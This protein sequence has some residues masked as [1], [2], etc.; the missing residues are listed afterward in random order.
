MDELKY[1]Y[2][3]PHY[4]LTADC[5]IFGFDGRELKVLLVERGIE[6]YKGCAALPG[7][8]M[9]P[10]ESL[11]ECARRE[12]IEETGLE[13]EPFMEEVGTY[14]APGRDPRERVVTTAF[15]ALVRS[16]EVKGGDD[17][18]SASWHPIAALP[19]LAFDHELILADALRRLRELIYFRP[20]G[21]DLLPEKFTMPQLQ[22]LYEAILGVKFDRR[23]FAKKMLHVGIIEET[24]EKS[25]VSTRRAANLYRFRLESYEAMKDRG[26][27]KMEF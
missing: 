23:N 4:A 11:E 10:D 1:C 17:A 9:K 26:E 27:W 18:A 22:G 15:M 21:H 20:V 14:S 6:P 8:F 7:G 25:A 5:V 13:G 12:L 19:P 3:Y 16:S 2:K 24:G